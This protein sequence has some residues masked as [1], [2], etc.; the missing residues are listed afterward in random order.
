[1]KHQ[2]F[3]QTMTRETQKVYADTCAAKM[4]KLSIY[5]VPIE[6]PKDGYHLARLLQS[7]DHV[8]NIAE[9]H[10]FTNY[11]K[12]V[13]AKNNGFSFDVTIIDHVGLT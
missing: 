3:K 8:R 6:L 2:I 4:S 12:L 1:M 7:S 9:I 5:K 11:I 10:I 13:K